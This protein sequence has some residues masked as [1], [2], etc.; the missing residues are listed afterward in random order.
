[1]NRFIKL[2]AVLFTVILITANVQFA[3]VVNAAEDVDGTPE[4]V[5][6]DVDVED[7]SATVIASGSNDLPPLPFGSPTPTPYTP[8]TLPPLPDGQTYMY[9]LYNKNSGEHF[10]SGNS[11]E[12]DNLVRYGWT[13]EGV[14]WIAPSTGTPV[15]RVYNRYAGDHHYT[16]NF[17]EVQMLVSAGWNYEGIGWYSADNTGAPLYRLYNPY[18]TGA[19]SHHYTTSVSERDYLIGVGWRYEG[20]GWYGVSN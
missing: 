18:C 16:T 6:E 9:R 10:Y 8:P 17:S 15:Y 11:L 14:A 5:A 13:Y 7:T 2:L 3:N 20:I 1:M 4:T 19:G 12:R